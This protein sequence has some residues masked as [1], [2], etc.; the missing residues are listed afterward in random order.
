MSVV[1]ADGHSRMSDADVAVIADRVIGG[2]MQRPDGPAA[3]ALT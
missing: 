3:A 1:T 2:R